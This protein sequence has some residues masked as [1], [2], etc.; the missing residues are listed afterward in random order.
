MKKAAAHTTTKSDPSA[1]FSAGVIGKQFLST[2]WRMA[3]PVI[4]LTILGLFADR[5]WHTK[6]WCTFG[7]VA[8]GFGIALW[9]IKRELDALKGTDT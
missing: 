9:L 8:V 1:L 4:S 5:H 3:V 2:T 7:G 6:P